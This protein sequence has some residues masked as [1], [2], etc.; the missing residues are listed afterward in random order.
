MLCNL[1]LR[2]ERIQSSTTDAVDVMF[3]GCERRGGII[4]SVLKSLEFVG[5][6]GSRIELFVEFTVLNMKLG[7]TDADDWAFCEFNVESSNIEAIS[8]TV[9]FMPF[10]VLKCELTTVPFEKLIVRLDPLCH[11]GKS[12]AW[13]LGKWTQVEPIK[14]KSDDIEKQSSTTQSCQHCEA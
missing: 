12:W 6:S 7:W 11:G 3:V 8:P 4:E 1:A 2:K 14:A 10:G 13:K 9:F 5:C